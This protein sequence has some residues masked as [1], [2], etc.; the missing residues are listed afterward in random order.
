MLQNHPLKSYKAFSDELGIA[1]LT[2]KSRCERIF[3]LYPQSFDVE[4]IINYEKIQ[5]MIV[6]VFLYLKQPKFAKIVEDILHNHNY[7]KFTSRCIGI[8]NSS[9]I[10]AQFTIP[11]T[12]LTL[13]KDFLN[14]MRSKNWIVK[15]DYYIQSQNR[16]TVLPE[17]FAWNPENNQWNL[18]KLSLNEAFDQITN[19]SSELQITPLHQFPLKNLNS[20]HLIIL[21]EL[22]FDARRSTRQIYQARSQ[23]NNDPNSLIGRSSLKLESSLTKFI[24][25]MNEVDPNLTNRN[26][27]NS[28]ISHQGLINRY[29]LNYPTEL[30]S[31][32][33]TCLFKGKFR[34]PK[35]GFQ[36]FNLLQ[37]ENPFKLRMSFS[38]YENGEFS[39]FIPIPSK[40]YSSFYQGLCDFIADEFQI[41]WLNYGSSGNFT[42]WP[43]N[44]N[45][46]TKSW[47]ID[48]E[49][50]IQ[51]PFSSNS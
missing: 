5:L 46:E 34:D 17:L 18:S 32:Y 7:I 45:L 40:F 47:I 35:I 37:Q 15:F 14:I 28:T 25:T 6:D 48:E 51:E 22:S 24:T 3:S 39:W 38:I 4:G 42:F 16:I 13:L 8:G 44:F 29:R 20:T 19:H 30:F 12:A 50:F 11:N 41:L 36:I 31:I 49:Y 43:E 9:G 21:E 2:V 10:F 23:L 33:D 1:P 26:S 27:I